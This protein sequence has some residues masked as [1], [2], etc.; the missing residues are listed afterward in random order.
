MSDAEASTEGERPLPPYTAPAGWKTTLRAFESEEKARQVGDFVAG[1]VHEL[2]RYIDLHN[3]DGITIA[4]DYREALRDVDL[5]FET[6][7]T[8]EPTDDEV[9]G[10]A[11]TASVLRHGRVKSHMV[12]NAAFMMAIVDSKSEGFGIALHTLA[13]ECAHVEVVGKLDA[14]FP[15]ETIN[16]RFNSMHAA[17]RRSVILSCWEE[18]E[19][20]RLCARFGDDP[21]SSYESIFVD[22]L[23]SARPAANKLIIAYRTHGDVDR[24][25]TGIYGVYANVVKYAS[26]LLG[27]LH[28]RGR[29][30]T[31]LPATAAA[32]TDHWFAPYVDRLLQ[33]YDAIAVDY[34]KWTDRSTFEVVGD[35]IDEM[36]AEGG[37]IVTDLGDGR[38]YVA[39]PFTEET[40][41]DPGSALA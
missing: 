17:R 20:T 19:V 38:Q 6:T 31:D 23:R 34:G 13:H 26:Y 40:I 4:F 12:F 16:A 3:L 22:Q 1:Y 36:L 41:P 37:V 35:L 28:G 5:G 10:I 14:A 2:S 8:L 29:S 32:L 11:M 39:V 15:G 7:Q 18:Y 24:L 27:T 30:L 25:L 21:T 33:A 9:V